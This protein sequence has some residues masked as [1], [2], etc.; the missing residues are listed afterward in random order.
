MGEKE[1]TELT[2]KEILE[3][4]KP[5][6]LKEE[7]D[8]LLEHL[9][10]TKKEFFAKYK[11]CIT[12]RH[13]QLTNILIKAELTPRIKK[14]FER[15]EKL[16]FTVTPQEMGFSKSCE[17][18]LSSKESDIVNVETR[19]TETG[20]FLWKTKVEIS[21]IGEFKNKWLSWSNGEIMLTDLSFRDC[22]TC[23]LDINRIIS[24]REGL[25]DNETSKLTR[26][27]IPESKYLLLKS[28]KLL[29]YCITLYGNVEF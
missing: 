2:L 8:L 12:T 24:E 19:R 6:K 17:I 21:D 27:L 28:Q 29:H 22:F 13:S 26:I 3:N 23:S 14:E 18:L 1:M 7:F 11:S 4:F 15:T 25:S 9:K 16:E 5:T 20:I 10:L